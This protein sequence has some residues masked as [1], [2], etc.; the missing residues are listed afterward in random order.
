MAID[1]LVF[2]TKNKEVKTVSFL[3]EYQDKF[4]E[5]FIK[6]ENKNLSY[7]DASL[8]AL[9]KTKKFKVITF[10]ENLIKI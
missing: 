1:F 3:D 9:H 2:T 5:E 4:S 8:L 7:I 6:P 10:D